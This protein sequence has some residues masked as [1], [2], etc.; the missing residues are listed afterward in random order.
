MKMFAMKVIKCRQEDIILVLKKIDEKHVSVE[1]FCPNEIGH[2][3]SFYKDGA[4]YH[5]QA[6]FDDIHSAAKHYIN[7][8]NILD[9]NMA[10]REFIMDFLEKYF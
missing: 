4:Y 7:Y 3:T 1:V 8:H 9:D 5:C 10:L 2:T 6:D